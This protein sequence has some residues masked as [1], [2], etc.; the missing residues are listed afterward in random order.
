VAELLAL[1]STVDANISASL[2]PEG[3]SGIAKG[4]ATDSAEPPEQL[5]V[6]AD[7]AAIGAD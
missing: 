5:C 4:A 1:L 3:A 7:D 6:V 2:R